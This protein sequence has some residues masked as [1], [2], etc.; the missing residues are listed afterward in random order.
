M[1]SLVLCMLCAAWETGDLKFGEGKRNARLADTKHGF[2]RLNPVINMRFLA[3]CA[4]LASC[5]SRVR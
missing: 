5:E 2:M 3:I 4:A 1:A